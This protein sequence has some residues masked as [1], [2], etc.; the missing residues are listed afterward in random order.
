MRLFAYEIVCAGG[1]GHAHD[2]LRAEGMAML[3][4]VAVDF[5]AAGAN[6]STL[7][8]PRCPEIPGVRCEHGRVADERRNFDRLVAD[9][10]AVLVIA[11]E[12]DDHL[13]RRSERVLELGRPLLG[14]SPDAVR[15]AGDKL[16]LARRWRTQ[17]VPTPATEP[18]TLTPAARYPAVLKPRHGAGSIATRLVQSRDEWPAAWAESADEMPD[19]IVQPHHPGRAASIAFLVGDGTMVPLEP[20]EQILSADG[21]FSY[22]GGRFPLSDDEADRARHLGRR[23]LAGIDGLAGY[24]G[25]DLVLGESD[26]VIEVNPRLTT[27][28]VGLRQRTGRNLAKAW[29]DLRAG[30]AVE[31]IEWSPARFEFTVI[32]P[33]PLESRL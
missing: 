2:S 26:W 1:L 10:D 8:T 6:V 27:S 33:R 18:A 11:P 31:P 32:R 15:L 20:A 28:Y 25:V 4:A 5:A 14:C 30:Q 29:L 12:F 17:G 7:L 24:V 19:L 21:R 23:A 16:A 3:A 9:A 22:L 13:L